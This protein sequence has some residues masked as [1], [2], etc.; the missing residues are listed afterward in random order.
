M[1][2]TTLNVVGILAGG[3]AGLARHRSFSRPTETNLK[4]VLGAFTVYYGLRLT[5][6]SVNGSL[7]QVLKQLCVAILAMMA[8]KAA[9]KLLRLQTLS[10]RLGRDASARI[11]A[12][13]P[14]APDR[15]A[16]GFTVCAT[17]FCAAPLGI[18][19]ALQDGLS[20]YFYP[21]AIKAVMDGLAA[22]GFVALFGRGVLLAAL[23]VLALQ[24]TLTLVCGE[25]LG[26]F[27]ASRDLLD[28]VNAAGGLIVF[29]VAL[30]ILGLK[31]IEMADY[32]PSL[33]FAPLITWLW[34]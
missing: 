16:A 17:L 21:L 29:S 9:G 3:V 20:G 1:I 22:M 15:F 34:R 8:G 5:W 33:A 14:N 27:L 23:P 13:R 12:V 25:F 32:L 30:V 7:F 19:G 31:R 6:L 4:V 11:S 26:P 10:N 24:G 2:G 28:S 18:I